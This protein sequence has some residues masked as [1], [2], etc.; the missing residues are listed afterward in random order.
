VAKTGSMTV[1]VT[2]VDIERCWVSG[3]CYQTRML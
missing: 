1:G 2:A 3:F